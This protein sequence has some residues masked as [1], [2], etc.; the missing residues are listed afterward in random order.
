M[1]PDRSPGA[2][3][4]GLIAIALLAFAFVTPWFT[5]DFSSGRQT[6]ANGMQ[7]KEDTGVVRHNLSDAPFTTQ[8]DAA[9]ADPAQHAQWVT[10]MGWLT[11]TALFCGV[12]IVLAEVPGVRRVLIRGVSVGAGFVGAAALTGAA[13]VA[14]FLI[15]PSV[16]IG[17]SPFTSVQQAD[18]YWRTSLGYGWVLAALAMPM[19]LA[20]V[21]N[22]FQAGSHDPAAIEDLA[23]RA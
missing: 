8:G 12:V 13:L 14:W 5:A 2:L 22:K 17:D 10:L 18:G 11:A 19:L 16:G 23:R 20:A 21:A 3:A 9:A 6:P 1:S 7:P 15:P 4:F